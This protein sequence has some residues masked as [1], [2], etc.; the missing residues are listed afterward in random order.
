MWNKSVNTYC[1]WFSKVCDGLHGETQRKRMQNLQIKHFF[2]K[3]HVWRVL[4][5]VD[6]GDGGMGGQ[7]VAEHNT[8]QEITGFRIE[9]RCRKSHL[10]ILRL[11][12]QVGEVAT[13]VD[14]SRRAKGV[15]D[16][17][18]CVLAF[19]LKPGNWPL[20]TLWLKPISVRVE[21]RLFRQ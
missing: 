4:V 14:S 19:N 10:L 17:P 7:Q 6:F 1:I 21:T 8:G 5:V 11:A 15:E 18:C 16:E 2:P 9:S 13:N 3:Q 20:T 12:V